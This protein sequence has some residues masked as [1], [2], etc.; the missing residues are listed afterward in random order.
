MKKKP[1]CIAIY[2]PQFHPIPE[3]DQWWGKGFTE[4]TNVGKAKALY[5]GHYQP[6]VPADLGYYDLRMEDI[7][8]AQA[9]LAK[10]YGIDA[11]CYWN[12]WFGEG[13]RLLERPLEEFLSSGKPDFPICIGWANHSWEAKNWGTKKLKNKILIQQKYPGLEDCQ[14]HYKNISRAFKDE[15][16]LKI[17]GKPIFLIWDPLALPQDVDY[18]KIWRDLAEG[19]GYPGIIFIGF[20]YFRDKI[21]LIRNM[22]FDHV[23][24][25]GLFEA[26]NS[27]S[28]FALVARKIVRELFG[29]P[30]KVPYGVYA[31]INENIIQNENTIPCIL[32]NY[33]H[34]P[35]SGKRGVVLVSSPKAYEGHL[36]RIVSMIEDDQL[37]S[38]MLFLKSWNEWGEGNHLEPDLKY[39]HAYLTAT[40]SALKR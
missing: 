20:T 12:Y 33:D 21:S 28:K 13:K 35:R 37:N 9:Q 16:Y 24:F 25:D 29:S 15:R 18:L 31:K 19:D 40:R 23:L 8:I 14:N 6:R 2:L 39:G 4:W 1:V 17:D 38:Q 22:G 26:R 34:T 3:N 32:P 10:E 30:M 11:F 36:S 5:K 7:R 27:G